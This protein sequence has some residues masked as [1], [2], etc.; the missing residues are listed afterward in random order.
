MIL[1]D[2]VHGPVY[3]DR[4]LLSVAST[5]NLISSPQTSR[6]FW[7]WGFG[8]WTKMEPSSVIDQQQGRLTMITGGGGFG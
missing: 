4:I 8:E 5:A 6:K 7:R 3:G 2:Y 1:V